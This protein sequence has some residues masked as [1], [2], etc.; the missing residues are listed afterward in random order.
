MKKYPKTKKSPFLT[1]AKASLIILIVI[2][3]VIMIPMAGAG[4][5]YNSDSYGKLYPQCRN[6]FDCFGTA[7]DNFLDSCVSEKKYCRLDFRCS[8]ICTLYVYALYCNESC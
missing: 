5:I 8:R 4:L 3:S 6:R 1:V 7:Y 2:F